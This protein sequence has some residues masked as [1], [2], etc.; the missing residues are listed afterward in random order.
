MNA[1]TY[2]VNALPD[3]ALCLHAANSLRD[4]CDHNRN[5][6]APHI[7]AFGQLHAGLGNI[8]VR[9]R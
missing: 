5:A 4:L 7:S 6:L 8:P 9:V 3:Q 2:V 1:I